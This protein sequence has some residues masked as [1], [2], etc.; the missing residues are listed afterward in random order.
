MELDQG[1]IKTIFEKEHSFYSDNAKCRKDKRLH[2]FTGNF[3]LSQVL[4][5]M[6]ILDLGC[7]NGA[8]L[9]RGYSR[10]GYG[11]GI[12]NDPDH[13]DIAEEA[14][15]RSDVANVE[16]RLLDF[17]V[18]A[19][20]LPDGSFDFIFSQ[21][22]PLDSRP[23]IQAALRILRSDGVVFSEEIGDQHL[24]EVSEI[25]ESDDEQPQIK[26]LEQRRMEMLEFGVDVRI[27]AD[28]ITK[29]YYPDIYEWLQF[30][31]D[32]WIWLDEALPEADDPRLRLFAER[33]TT[34]TG[35]IETTHH[36]TWIGG[37]KP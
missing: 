1:R 33:N 5:E 14:L 23:T 37:V 3:I 35:E 30:Q 29:W 31:C 7:G 15:K 16:F 27:A 28:I 21:R 10:F 18:H 34:T 17:E 4:P 8:T 24:H 22:G 13:I 25:F 2:P 32:I 6:R 26:T 36:V 19:D 11:L 12:D 9:L 20:E